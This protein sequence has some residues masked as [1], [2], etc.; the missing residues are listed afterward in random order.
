[1]SQHSQVWL[2]LLIGKAHKVEVVKAE[3]VGKPNAVPKNEDSRRQDW[4]TGPLNVF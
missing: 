1:M 3:D 2:V 4:D